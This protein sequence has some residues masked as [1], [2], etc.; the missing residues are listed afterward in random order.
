MSRAYRC[1][2]CLAV[3]G[4]DPY[5]PHFKDNRLRGFTLCWDNGKR[6]EP[7]DLCESC[8][9]SMREWWAIPLTDPPT[10]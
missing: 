6:L 2:R 1:D 3:V 5:T 8:R 4:R 7:Y 10:T 9:N